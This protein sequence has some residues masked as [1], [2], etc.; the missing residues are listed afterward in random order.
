MC[1][2]SYV[3]TKNGFILTSNRDE[4]IER[5]NLKTPSYSLIAGKKILYPKDKT[6]NGTWI[7]TDGI[8]FSLCLFNGAYKNHVPQAPYKESRGNIIYRFFS[9]N[10]IIR[11]ATENEFSGM[12]PFSLII[13]QHQ[14]MKLWLFI[15][16]GENTNLRKL[17]HLEYY[18]WSSVTLYSPEVHRRKKIAFIENIKAKKNP[19]LNMIVDLHKNTKIGDTE[20]DFV[21]HRDN[22][23]TLS[24]T[25]IEM[26]NKETFF[27]HENLMDNISTNIIFDENTAL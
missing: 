6:T 20:N 24:I 2:V 11:F 4:K 10:S 21:M 23:Q 13:T 18:L 26:K 12:E 7:A 25:S 22:L 3:P 9:T 14:P 15:W 5:N 16:D 17:N 19:K 27:Y 1:T 8:D